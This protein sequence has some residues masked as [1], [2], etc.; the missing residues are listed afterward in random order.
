MSEKMDITLWMVI[1][2]DEYYVDMALLSCL[3]YVRNVYVQDQGST[4]GSRGK[5][6]D[7]INNWNEGHPNPVNYL[8]EIEDTGL[9]RFDPEYNEPHYRSLAIRRATEIFGAE[10][11]LQCDADDMFTPRFFNAIALL[12][13]TD[14]LDGYNSVRHASER[15]ITPEYRAWDP[16]IHTIE[17]VQYIDP[18][19]RLWRASKGCQYVLNP[20]FKNTFLHCVLQPHPGPEYWIPGICNIHLHRTFGPKSWLFWEEGGDVFERT[21]PFNPARQA[22]KWFNAEV[23]MGKAM[24]ITDKDYEWPEFVVSKW[25]EWMVYD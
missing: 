21:I 14:V 6:A 4:D 19:T 18:H 23:N 7:T 8:I 10:W 15:F 5:I 1:K 9:K 13:K 25:R 16:N 11:L 12:D 3:P 2:N 17:G 22:P 24:K 20:A